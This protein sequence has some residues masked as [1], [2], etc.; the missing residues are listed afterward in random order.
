MAL[1]YPAKVKS[2]HTILNAVRVF[3]ET[4]SAIERLL[5]ACIIKL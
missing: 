4:L 5:A 2:I 1:Q 3:R